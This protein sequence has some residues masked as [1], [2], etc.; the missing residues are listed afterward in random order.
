MLAYEP[1]RRPSAAEVERRCIELRPSI[2]GPALRYWAED[3]VPAALAA[4]DAPAPGELS[5]ETFTVGNIT[6][7]HELSAGL[8]GAAG[9]DPSPTPPAEPAMAPVVVP[10]VTLD[11]PTLDLASQDQAPDTG[12]EPPPPVDEGRGTSEPTDGA[13][14]PALSEDFATFDDLEDV[15]WGTSSGPSAGTSRWIGLALIGLLTCVGFVLVARA[16]LDGAG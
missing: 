9:E 13:A 15:P 14:S 11:T 5:G 4:M 2:G 16:W 10:E 1:E 3:V 8:A 6:D 7:E 12:A